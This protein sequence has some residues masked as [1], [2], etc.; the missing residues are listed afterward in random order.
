M[1]RPAVAEYPPGAQ[2]ATRVIDDYEL[3]WMLRGRARLVNT[4]DEVWLPP[5]KLLLIPPA[6]AHAIVWD[7]DRSSQHGYVHFGAEHFAA[8]L[9]HGFVVHPMTTDDPL[10]G[11]CS[12]LLWLGR[13]VD[14]DWRAR[15]SPVLRWLLTV[16]VA[17]PLPSSDPS[18]QVPAPVVAAV[19][20]LR[21][22]WS[23]YPLPRITVPELA[24]AVAVSP[25]YLQRMFRA[26]FGCSVGE[27]LERARCSRAEM[28][29]AGTSLTA[30]AIG[31]N[32]GFADLC[33]F[34]HRFAAI[35]GMPPSTYRAL[36]FGAPS[37]L[38]DPGIRRFAELI[39]TWSP[40]VPSRAR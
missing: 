21:A 16:F 8:G 29:L 27:A 6:V 13:R 24:R 7:P 19:D 1:E 23:G 3:V 28:M 11:L 25:G 30:D 4:D 38:D 37:L 33:H 22:Q 18:L 17:G 39:W 40:G 35:H 20:H 31:R 15:A 9:P 2:L 10:A 36:A 14:D 12:Y 34:S 5:G 26:T 32:C